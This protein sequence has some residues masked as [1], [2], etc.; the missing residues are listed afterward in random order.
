MEETKSRGAG[1]KNEVNEWTVWTLSYSSYSS[2]LRMETRFRRVLEMADVFRRPYE[3]NSHSP[4][5]WEEVLHMLP[6]RFLVFEGEKG[7]HIPR[8]VRMGDVKEDLEI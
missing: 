1:D 2:S 5:G 4:E 8:P 7:V 6:E 3:S